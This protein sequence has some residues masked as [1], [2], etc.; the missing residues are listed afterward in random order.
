VE[1]RDS[2]LDVGTFDRPRLSR[3]DGRL[4]GSCCRDCGAT[5]WPSRALCHR[6]GSA[7][8]HET[9]I[10]PEGTLVSYT[11]V[12]V[13]RPGIEAPYTIG[14]VELPE[15]VTVFAHIHGVADG[16]SVPLPVRLAV[17]DEGHVPPF[18]FEVATA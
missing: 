10:G 18:H 1:L 15:R 7:S 14:E 5:S 12:W 11:V 16:A 2:L 3:E 17:A 4:V 6:C 8:V 13:P 9:L